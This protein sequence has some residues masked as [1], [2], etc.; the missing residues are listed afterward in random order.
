MKAVAKRLLV[1][2]MVMSMIVPFLV[3]SRSD[4]AKKGYYFS[5]AGVSVT[6]GSKAKK[7]I[8]KAGTPISLKKSKSCAFKGYDRIRKYSGFILYTYTKTKTGPEYVNGITF[9]NGSVKTNEG[10]R[11]G[12]TESEMKSVY[13]NGT[14]SMGVYMYNKGKTRLMLQIKD[15]RVANIKYAMTK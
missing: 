15:G 11:I 3:E 9:L 5:N 4:A 7:F 2:V 13:G 1:F 6:M 14:N 12:S 10:I 8:K